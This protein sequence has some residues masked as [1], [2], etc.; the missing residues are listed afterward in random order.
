MPTWFLAPIAGHKLTA[1]DDM[2]GQKAAE[3]SRNAKRRGLE[4]KG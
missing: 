1:Q 4:I 3:D 2:R